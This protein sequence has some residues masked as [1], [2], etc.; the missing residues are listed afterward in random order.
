MANNV[1]FTAVDDNGFSVGG[2]KTLAISAAGTVVV[3]AAPGRLC[4]VIVTATASGPVTF[5]DNA[6]TGSGTVLGVVPASAAVGALYEFQAP[7][8]NGI[9]AVAAATPSSVTVVY[10]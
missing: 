8:A 10:S 3:K 2:A 1:V 9:T 7:A 4:R 6:T 5:Y